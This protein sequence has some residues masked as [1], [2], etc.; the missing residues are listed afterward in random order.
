MNGVSVINSTNIIQD[1]DIFS[2]ISVLD[3]WDK[4]KRAKHASK[5]AVLDELKRDIGDDLFYSLSNEDKQF[6]LDT[7]GSVDFGYKADKNDLKRIFSSIKNDY[8]Y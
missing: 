1:I 7:E 5:I 2:N 6:I 4:I 3:Y 8:R